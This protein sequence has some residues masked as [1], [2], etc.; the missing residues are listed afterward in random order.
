VTGDSE[1]VHTLCSV[2]C[3]MKCGIF[4]CVLMVAAVNG[5]PDT[6]LEFQVSGSSKCH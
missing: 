1:W 4:F 5:D 6:Q 3:A 2:L